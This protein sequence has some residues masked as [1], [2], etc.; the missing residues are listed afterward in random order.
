LSI[1]DAPSSLRD[2][3][4]YARIAVA[5]TL[6]QRDAAV[7]DAILH[8]S[9]AQNPGRSPGSVVNR[10]H[11]QAEDSEGDAPAVDTTDVASGVVVHV[12]VPDAA[13]VFCGYMQRTGGWPCYSNLPSYQKGR[14][15][16]IGNH[17]K[18]EAFDTSDL[19]IA[20]EM[21]ESEFI[22]FECE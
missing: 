14:A 12:E 21:Y 19:F 1:I 18:L 9:Y 7:A 2:G 8:P 16:I 5:A 6:P 10:L 17:P 11:V 22:V 3:L 4:Q 15:A 20:Q 13:Q